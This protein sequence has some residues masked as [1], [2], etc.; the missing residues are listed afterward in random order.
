MQVAIHA[1]N[2][3]GLD[4]NDA[5]YASL[6]AAFSLRPTPAPEASRRLPAW[7]VFAAGVALGVVATLLAH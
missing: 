6:D 2:D 3:D 5:D 7:L 1:A 4:S